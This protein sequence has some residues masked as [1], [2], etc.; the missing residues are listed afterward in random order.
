MPSDWA[1]CIQKRLGKGVLLGQEVVYQ[2][3]M[4][5]LPHFIDEQQKQK[6][7][8]TTADSTQGPGSGLFVDYTGEWAVFLTMHGQNLVFA[9]ATLTK[10]PGN[11]WSGG[12]AQPSSQWEEFYKDVTTGKSAAKPQYEELVLCNVPDGWSF[13]HFMGT[14]SNVLVQ[15]SFV[16]EYFNTSNEKRYAV[17]TSGGSN[18]VVDHVFQA[19]GIAKTHQLSKTQGMTARRMVYPCNA[20]RNPYAILRTSEVLGVMSGP[21]HGRK[22]TNEAALIKGL[23]EL[24]AKRGHGERLQ[25]LHGTS[26]DVSE[27]VEQFRQVRAIIGAHGGALF[28]LRFAHPGTLVMELSNLDKQH[29]PWIFWYDSTVMGAS[30]HQVMCPSSGND[31]TCPV[32]KIISHLG[33]HL[34]KSPGTTMRHLKNW[35]TYGDLSPKDSLQFKAPTG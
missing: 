24:L 32:S 27:V 28:N 5:K 29:F 23:E 14:G 17:V 21:D 9:D 13:Q 15:S 20:P 35:L 11:S 34:G 8:K 16:H 4:L 6:W 25:V 19:M 2:G 10:S 12:C 30:Y 33:Q 26:G 22:V 18:N 1:P 7:I 3:F 31:I